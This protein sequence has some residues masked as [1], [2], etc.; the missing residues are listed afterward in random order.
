MGIYRSISLVYATSDELAHRLVLTLRDPVARGRVVSAVAAGPVELA[1]LHLD[2]AFTADTRSADEKVTAAKGLPTGT[3]V[4][5]V[6]LAD[7]GMRPVLRGGTVPLVAATPTDDTATNLVGYDPTGRAASIDA[8]RVPDRP[9][10]L[11]EVDTEKAVPLGIDIVQQ[12]LAA[13]G[14][15]RTATAA[16]A[17]ATGGYWATKVDAVRL[18]DDEEPWFKGAAEIYSIVGGTAPDGTAKVDIVQM[19]YLDD[20]GVTYYP[21]QLLVGF[22]DYKYNLAD[23]VMMEDDGDTNYRQLA[24]AIASALLTVLDIGVYAPLV[25]A[26]LAAIPTS[27]YTDDPEASRD[28]RAARRAGRTDRHADRAGRATTARRERRQVACHD[29]TVRTTR[30]PRILVW[31]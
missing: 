19:P 22:N 4:L 15:R 5:Q 30:P 31:Y 12:R 28:R 21:N 25:S 11:V 7:P 9:L 1:D 20:D 27:W 17:D 14:V 24:Q 16:P 2:A 13:R 26:I 6:R 10:L 8:G 23:V 3:T 29:L 18:S